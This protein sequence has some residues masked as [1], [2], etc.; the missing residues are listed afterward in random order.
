[1][2]KYREVDTTKIISISS[3]CSDDFTNYY[4]NDY[5]KFTR[6]DIFHP[7]ELN[8][9]I[10]KT[11]FNTSPVILGNWAHIKKGKNLIPIMKSKLTT[12]KFQQLNVSMGRDV[13]LH[14][15]KKQ[16]IYCNADIFLQ[17]SNSEGNSYATLDAM[18]CGLVIVASNVG[19]FYKD[20]P[21]N[22]FVKLE[23]SKNNDFEYVE[24]QLKYAWENRYELSK[25]ARNWY[26][27]NY[28]FNDWKSKMY[29]LTGCPEIKPNKSI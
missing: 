5:S 13:S 22:C 10:Y 29:N 4:Q 16:E 15:S 9:N 28:G 23:W 7:S 25:N 26:L 11:S 2:L 8:E 1:M 21:D 14:N 17:I 20:V 27:N 6:I 24:K 12:F 3:A 19:L 18:M